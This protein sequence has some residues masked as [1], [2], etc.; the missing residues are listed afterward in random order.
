M[1]A[2]LSHKLHLGTFINSTHIHRLVNH[3][4]TTIEFIDTNSLIEHFGNIMIF[5]RVSNVHLPET[6]GNIH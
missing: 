1:E 4:A 5:K 2:N 6:S 3:F